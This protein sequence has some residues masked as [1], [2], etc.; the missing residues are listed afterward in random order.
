[1]AALH[2]AIEAGK[3]AEIIAVFEAQQ[4]ERDLEALALE[5]NI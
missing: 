1:M 4:G 5:G 2:G 3:L